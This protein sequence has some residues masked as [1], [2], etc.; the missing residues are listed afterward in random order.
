[1]LTQINYLL[2]GTWMI[3][4]KSR[5][6]QISAPTSGAPWAARAYSPDTDTIRRLPCFVKQFLRQRAITQSVHGS[7]TRRVVGGGGRGLSTRT[8]FGTPQPQLVYNNAGAFVKAVFR[9]W[10]CRKQPLATLCADEESCRETRK[11]MP[12]PIFLLVLPSST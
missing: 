2:S 4:F 9:T 10:V 7:T 5:P 3:C 1:M 12:L 8:R 6:K 11:A